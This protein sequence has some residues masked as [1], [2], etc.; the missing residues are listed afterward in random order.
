MDVLSI[1]G[2]INVWIFL[3]AF[4][5]VGVYI[6]VKW[7]FG[8]WKRLGV[9]S[10]DY[11]PYIG[12]MAEIQKQGIYEFDKNLITKYGRVVGLQIGGNPSLLIADPEI[13]KNISVKEFSKAPNRFQH[14]SG[15]KNEMRHG[16]TAVEDDHWRF[17]RNTLLPTFSSGKMR[18]MDPLL[19]VK[20]KL[21]L[22]SLK[23]NADEGK[24]I[25]FKQTFGAYTMDVIASLGFGMDINSQTNPDNLFVTYTKELM[26]F[27]LSPLTILLVLIPKLDIIFDYFNV[28]PLNNRRVMGF[29]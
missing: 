12:G 21:L 17:M 26:N 28:S 16:L 13:I 1:L 4:V 6:H 10:P 9:P 2:N 24:P 22:D 29:F 14:F 3:I 8:F 5:F 23:T 7:K 20:Y 25:D 27:S 11:F 15:S 18:K 19:R